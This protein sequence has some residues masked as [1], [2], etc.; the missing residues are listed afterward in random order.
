MIAVYCPPCGG[1]QRGGGEQ[2]AGYH[3][4]GLGHA[5]IELFAKALAQPLRGASDDPGD[6]VLWDT[7]TGRCR[8]FS[9]SASLTTKAVL[10]RDGC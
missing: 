6:V 2:R 7:E 10:A 8:T 5:A 1:E 9:R 4:I 3:R